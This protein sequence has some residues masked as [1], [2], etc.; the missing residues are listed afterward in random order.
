MAAEHA[1]QTFDLIENASE[2]TDSYSVGAVSASD[3]A[4]ANP[5]DALANFMGL[6]NARSV[7]T[8]DVTVNAS[9]YAK[10]FDEKLGLA[11]DTH[12]VDE[13]DAQKMSAAWNIMMTRR[14][15]RRDGLGALENEDASPVRSSEMRLQLSTSTALA[16][17]GRA[18]CRSRFR[19]RVT[20][21][22][23]LAIN[24]FLKG[25]TFVGHIALSAPTGSGDENPA[26]SARRRRDATLYG[27][28]AA[29]RAMSAYGV[30]SPAA[31]LSPRMM[32]PLKSCRWNHRCRPCRYFGR[33]SA[34]RRLPTTCSA[35]WHYK[36]GGFED[37]P[38]GGARRR[39]YRDRQPACRR[40][41]RSRR[42]RLPQVTTTSPITA[43]RR[44]SSS[45]KSDGVDA[46]SSRSSI[47][48]PIRDDGD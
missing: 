3:Q 12:T 7:W 18:S 32:R 20:L 37:A 15:S 2:Q 39:C 30:R 19:Q 14:I 16:K 27:R 35:G 43:K 38:T 34:I 13:G 4:P 40:E 45:A 23:R 6:A 21:A 17:T 22:P 29:P 28:W 11:A 44:H 36:L 9:P 42:L 5:I 47:A 48:P 25:L 31:A 10:A 33:C 24:C 41:V 8:V 1:A 46:N 26:T